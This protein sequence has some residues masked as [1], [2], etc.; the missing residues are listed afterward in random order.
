MIVN[1]YSMRDSFIF[2]RSFQD[3]IDECSQEDQLT[4][5]KAIANYALDRKE[6]EL[7]GVAKVCWVLIKPQLD[8]N[9]KRYD[10]G[11]KGGNHGSKGGAP[12]GNRNAYK[13]KTTPKQPQNNPIAVEKT[14]PNNNVNDNVNLN[15]NKNDKDIIET[16]VSTKRE[17][18]RFTKPTLEELKNYIAENSY[19]VDAE[20]FLDYYESNGWRVGKNPMKNWQAAVRSWQ[21]QNNES[22]NTKCFSASTGNELHSVFDSVDNSQYKE[23]DY[24]ERF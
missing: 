20:R 22:C 3:A 13:G 19:T 2:Y 12:K 10:N 21:R 17:T 1:F 9:W 18:K 14:T 5:Y 6:P 11:C 16:K 7:S 4:I 24:S 8:A 23:K 15:D